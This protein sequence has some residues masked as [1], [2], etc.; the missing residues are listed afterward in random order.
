[1]DSTKLIGWGGRA[2]GAWLAYRH[3]GS[4][5]PGGPAV[6]ALVGWIAGGLLADNLLP[7]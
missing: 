3:L 2:A 1:M 4:K 5:V 7:R 6:A